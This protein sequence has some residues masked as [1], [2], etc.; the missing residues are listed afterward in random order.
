MAT[1]IKVS[2]ET[3]Q[4]LDLLQARITIKTGEKISLQDVV[5]TISGLALRH[6]DEICRNRKLPPLE[7]DPAWKEAID[8]GVSTD[9]T[10]VDRHLYI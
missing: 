6:E 2:D 9:A 3:K 1:S 7:R 8:W 10:E 5:E 4:K